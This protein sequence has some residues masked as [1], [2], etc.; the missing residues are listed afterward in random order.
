MATKISAKQLSQEVL[1]LINSGGGALLR[2][3][4][5]NVAVG[6]APIG[7]KFPK[8]QDLTEF[9]EMIL[10]KDIIPTI[11]TN[12]TGSGIKE[13]GTSVNGTT[14][15]LNITN[16][17]QVTVPINKVE[18]FIN[19]TLVSS[20][21][22]IEGEKGYSFSYYNQITTDTTAKAVLTYNNSSVIQGSGTF[23]FVYG[24]FYGATT[25]SFI[26]S[27]IM[28]GLISTFNKSIKN[29]KSF[30]WDKITLNDERFCYAYPASM[31]TLSSIKDG[32]GFDQTQGYTRYQVDVT[33]PT[34]SQI[35][36]YYVYLLNE[37]T[38]GSGFKQI[39]S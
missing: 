38:T 27:A 29:T 32:N 18:F 25:A 11:Q 7:T 34:N 8:G 2:E 33:Y 17:S 10:R 26:D 16:L 21:P 12:F 13:I 9:A 24:S 22:Y 4:I 23:T 30:T 31:G 19:D 39:Y 37:P 1:D 35:V 3:I 20:Q 15:V 36:S 14:M 6:A 5:S 28:N